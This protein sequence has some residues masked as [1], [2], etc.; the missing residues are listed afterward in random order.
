MDPHDFFDQ[1]RRRNVYRVATA[2]AVVAWLIIQIATQL[3]PIFE[4]PHWVARA[5]ILLLLL[6]FPIALVLAWAFEL[7]PEGLKRTD[8]ISSTEPRPPTTGQRWRL[9]AIAVT[10]LNVALQISD[11][12]NPTLAII[13]V[14]V[15]I[16]LFIPSLRGKG[17]TA[18]RAG[19]RSWQEYVER[20]PVQLLINAILIGMIFGAILFGVVWSAI[21]SDLPISQSTADFSPS[22]SQAPV[23]T[24][25]INRHTPKQIYDILSKEHSFHKDEVAREFENGRVDWMLIFTSAQKLREAPVA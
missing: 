3:L 11:Y 7:T 14:V 25:H 24:R 5:V 6:G 21:R 20:N 9:G 12:K 19:K 13:L 15:A 4:I 16:C 22:P 10:L 1:L 18:W 2:Y 8:E 23:P 17:A